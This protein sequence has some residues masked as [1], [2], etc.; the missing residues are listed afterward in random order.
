MKIDKN[1]II[2]ISYDYINS[3]MTIKLKEKRVVN[4]F[5]TNEAVY[6]CSYETYVKC[7]IKMVKEEMSKLI[8]KLCECGKTFSLKDIGTTEKLCSSCNDKIKAKIRKQDAMRKAINRDDRISSNLERL[9][10]IDDK[11]RSVK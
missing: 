6:K 10:G 7:V 11:R 3:K 1:Q 9:G 2:Q 5:M 4:N 8:L